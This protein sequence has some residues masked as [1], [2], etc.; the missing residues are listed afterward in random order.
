MIRRSV[1]GAAV[2]LVLFH[3]YLFAWQMWNGEFAEPG[4][5]A[6]WLLG[7]VLLR[8]LVAARRHNHSMIWGRKALCIWLLAALLHG[9]ASARAGESDVTL[10]PLPP[11]I[12]TLL[13][14]TAAIGL[15][16]AVVFAASAA[17]RDGALAYRRAAVAQWSG[18][19]VAGVHSVLRVV[20]RP[21]PVF[22]P[23]S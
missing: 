8:G 23:L 2:L 17:R 21:P 19:R 9:P 14:I 16:L 5:L 20:P 11:A 7:A 10:A 6:R 3:A 13:Q 12:T 15:G 18:V 1:T 22:A 4:L